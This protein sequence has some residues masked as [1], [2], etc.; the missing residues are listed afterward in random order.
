MSGLMLKRDQCK[1][2]DNLNVKQKNEKH[3][4]KRNRFFYQKNCLDLFVH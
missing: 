2:S 1:I 3:D 4:E